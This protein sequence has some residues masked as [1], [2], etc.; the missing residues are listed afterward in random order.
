MGITKPA[1]PRY[2]PTAPTETSTPTPDQVD[3]KVK[4]EPVCEDIKPKVEDPFCEE[5]KPKV[6]DP[7]S[8]GIHAEEIDKKPSIDLQDHQKP[9]VAAEV[10]SEDE[11]YDD[12]DVPWI[13]AQTSTVQK[14]DTEDEVYSDDDIFEG[15]RDGNS[16]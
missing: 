1:L 5:T 12:E 7:I 14:S 9:S 16:A 13:K 4:V 10:V 6:E 8:V 15:K 3:I 11:D 2:L